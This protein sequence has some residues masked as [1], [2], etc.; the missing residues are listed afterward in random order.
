MIGITSAGAYLPRMR[1]QRSAIAAANAWFDPSLRGLGKGERT[2]CNW[3]EDPITMAV[4]AAQDC[5]ADGMGSNIDAVYFASTSAPFIDRQNAGV[6]AEALNLGTGLRTMDVGGSRRAATSATLAA[7][8]MARSNPGSNVLIA[9][10]ENRRARVGSPLEMIYGDGAAAL[11]IGSE[12]VIAE[13]VTAYN[14]AED[15]VDQYRGAGMG[16]DY[17]WEERW[18]RSEGYMKLVPKA[19]QGLMEKSNYTVGDIKHFIMPSGRRRV[20]E[21]AAKAAGIPADALVE[22]LVEN[23]GDTGAA[24]P[25][26]LFVLALERA[27]PGDLI[28]MTSFGQGC[29]ALLFRVTDLAKRDSSAL[30][31]SGALARGR[32]EENYAKYQTFN[33][34]VEREF[35]KRAETDKQ[36]YLSAFNRERDL[37]TG[38]TGGRCT[39]CGTIQIPRSEYCVNPECGKRNTQVP[40]ALASARGEVRTYTADQLTFD[41]NP[42]AYFGLVEFEG[43]GRLMVDFTEVDA[44]TFDVGT[45]VNMVFRIREIDGQRGFRK[46]FWKAVPVSG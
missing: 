9:A 41:M 42:P 46:Y 29:E 6:V 35:G 36:T 28:L 33:G 5:Q 30:R 12:G 7:I 20:P 11:C 22:N 17:E 23:C 18:V 43:G 45:K 38:F 34:L 15:F 10:A 4:S 16:H 37:L 19:V 2:M 44:D 8:D 3:D 31:V 21:S 39:A 26:V 13:F 1:L 40:Y 25:L 32:P 24:H 14:H 27:E